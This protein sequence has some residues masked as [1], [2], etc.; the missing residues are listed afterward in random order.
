MSSIPAPVRIR[1]SP[2]RIPPDTSNQAPNS[3]QVNCKEQT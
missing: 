1:P 2:G 3:N